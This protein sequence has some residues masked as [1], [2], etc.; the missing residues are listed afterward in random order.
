MRIVKENEEIERL[1]QRSQLNKQD[2]NE[3]VKAIIA[4][5]RQRGDAALTA[6]SSRFDRYD[7]A[8]TVT[9]AEKEAAYRQVPSETLAAL[10]RARDNIVAYH[11]RQVRPD[12]VVTEGDV[13]TGYVMRPVSRA[14]IYVPGGQA[15]YPSSVLMCACPA[16]VA[17]V[18]EIVMTTPAPNGVLNP[19]TVVA[20]CECGVRRIFKVGGAQAIAAMAYG[21]ETVPRV[22]VIAG[23]GNIYVAVAKRE[24]YGDVGIDM[25]AGPSEILIIADSTAK[26]AYL[27]ADI[28]SQAE[29]DAL[30]MSM[31][32]T[33]DAK[34]AE[35][36]VLCVTEQLEK[37]PKKDIAAAALERHG[38]VVLVPSLDAA[39][40]LAN[41]VSP[42]HLEL[43]VADTEALLPQVRNAGAVFLGNFTPEPVGDYYAGPNHVLPTSGTARFFSA[44]GVDTYCRRMSVVR[45][46]E[47]ALR[48]A[49]ED[50]VILAE[51]EG[52][53]AHANAI[54]IRI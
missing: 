42:E 38:A 28:L 25:I 51:T 36:T 54:K 6:Y 21:T 29:H 45:Y 41:R 15:A 43:C 2:V 3:T 16:L 50:I 46:G 17:G 33:T 30:S 52:L 27:A 18:D 19:L 8:L 49:A 47:N 12:N 34:L 23:P 32:L 44:L 4:D 13:T 37:L 5:V 1:L 26:P 39:V 40:K 14:G 11:K 35:S 20:A 24:V 7:G 22:D 31:L 10:R 48:A 53:Q 9:D